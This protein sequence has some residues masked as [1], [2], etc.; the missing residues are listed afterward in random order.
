MW[1]VALVL[2]K[3]V[4]GYALHQLIGTEG[5]HFSSSSGS[6]TIGQQLT[7]AA[8]GGLG[9]GQKTRDLVLSLWKGI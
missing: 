8:A 6:T 3:T 1:K 9:D 2:S 4:L 5:F 7:Q